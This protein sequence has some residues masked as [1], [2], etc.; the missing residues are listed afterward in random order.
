M[1]NKADPPVSEDGTLLV[2]M[3]SVMTPNKLIENIIG[4]TVM[5]RWNTLCMYAC[6]GRHIKKD[7]FQNH[8][9]CCREVYLSV[10]NTDETS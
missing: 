3:L 1:K 4:V 6:T 8:H 7:S 5:H 2:S 9:L 10:T